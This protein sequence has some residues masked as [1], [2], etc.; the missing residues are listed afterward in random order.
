M[1]NT[2]IKQE[3]KRL[4]DELPDNSTWDDLMYSIY[5]RQMV[6]AGI[7]DSGFP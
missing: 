2:N 3:A 4:I 6:E 1:E 5:V 7:A